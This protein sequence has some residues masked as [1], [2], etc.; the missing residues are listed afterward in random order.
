[1][2]AHHPAGTL[3]VQRPTTTM[4]G[5]ASN[6]FLLLIII[7][8]VSST[9]NV[10]GRHAA[11]TAVPAKLFGVANEFTVKNEFAG[12]PGWF[13]SCRG[14]LVVR[15]YDDTPPPPP[16]AN[17]QVLH[18][19]K[20][21]RGGDGNGM[22]APGDDD[23]A[24]NE[25]VEEST[26]QSPPNDD[27][28]DA[29]EVATQAAP[30]NVTTNSS[31]TTPPRQ[32]DKKKSKVETPFLPSLF[33]VNLRIKGDDETATRD[34]SDH[35]SFTTNSSKNRGG[36]LVKPPPPLPSAPSR[37]F[38]FKWFGSNNNNNNNNGRLKNKNVP[39]TGKIQQE[40][41]QLWWNSNASMDA[42]TTI[43]TQP[44]ELV[45]KDKDIASKIETNDEQAPETE[46]S[47]D[48]DDSQ[49]I[50]IVLEEEEDAETEAQQEQQNG[51]DDDI[52]PVEVVAEDEVKEEAKASHKK[53]HKKK[54]K[55]KPKQE[56]NKDDQNDEGTL[57]VVSKTTE[58]RQDASSSEQVQAT[59]ENDA[60]IKT[61]K[62][63]EIDQDEQTELEADKAGSYELAGEY[64][65]T[66]YT[67]SGAWVLIDGLVTLGYA[68]YHDAWKISR[69]LRPLRKSMAYWTGLHGVMSGKLRRGT[70]TDEGVSEEEDEALRN[71]LAAIDRARGNVERVEEETR[72]RE[73]QRRPFW[74]RNGEKD[75]GIYSDGADFV[76][77]RKLME[78]ERLRRKRLAE[79]DKLQETYGQTLAELAT[80]KELLLN[81]P[82]PLWNYTSTLEELEEERNQESQGR[83][84][85]QG[86]GDVASNETSVDGD[87]TADGQE[88]SQNLSPSREFNFPSDDLVDEYLDMLVSSGR[89][90]KLNH[91]NLWKNNGW[92]SRTSTDDE[93]DEEW[94]SAEEIERRARETKRR[95]DAGSRWLRNGLGEKIGVAVEMVAYKAVIHNV[96]GILAKGLS[97]MHGATVM[98]HSEIC[99]QTEHIPIL[100]PLAGDPGAGSDSSYASQAF[101]NVIQKT[102]SP[103]RRKKRKRKQ[104]Y[105]FVQRQAVAEQ[106]LSQCQIATPLLKLFPL[107]WQRALIGNIIS[108]ITSV[109]GDFIEGLEFEIL[110]HKLS[111]AFKPITEQDRWKKKDSG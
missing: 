82:N 10:Q 46:T 74:R 67:S 73:Q 49:D 80:E 78:Q 45:V 60:I 37:N 44:Q 87:N 62:E 6:M 20:I 100:P 5:T 90:T 59:T 15:H 28:N 76:R 58:T 72:I 57:V 42:T 86:Q 21:L 63:E 97:A 7:V 36:A 95:G 92:E 16:N 107:A 51:F 84:R 104:G 102:T 8:V 32:E 12:M 55:Q 25:I 83:Q 17:Q 66:P 13:F 48:S 111:L 14:C 29:N 34:G 81:I 35:F 53:K 11:A 43:P 56:N 77:N 108:V 93:D 69:S 75:K 110:G 18:S 96:M 40:V 24:S 94:L 19:W 106:L 38:L 1:M 50:R 109:V 105:D 79:I 3:V 47:D 33:Q 64:L 65:P 61:G 54:R 9:C 71:R 30:A 4:P 70:P 39:N 52:I 88:Q 91:T 68:N 89:L 2:Q 99:L 101:Q 103:H 22:S 31:S 98:G 27:S 41:E 23:T 26:E 85:Q